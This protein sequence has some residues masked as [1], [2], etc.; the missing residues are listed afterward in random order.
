MS[1]GVRSDAAA[2]ARSSVADGAG[3]CRSAA[4][5]L[6]AARG[7]LDLTFGSGGKVTTD[8]GGNRN[9]LGLA[10]QADRK[11]VAAGT[12]FD[13]G[14]SDDFVLAR[15]TA[16]GALDATFDRDGKVTTD[17]G[18]GSDGAH[19]VAIQADGKIVAA[20]RGIPVQGRPLDFALAVQPRRHAGRHVRRRWQAADNVRAEQHRRRERR[21]HPVGRQDRRRGS[22]RSGPTRRV[23]RREVPPNGSLDPSF[24]GDG[25]VVAAIPSGAV[26]DL[27]VQPDGKLIAAG[28]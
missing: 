18:G 26:F 25:L 22:T 9:S 27:A 2:E 20:G 17:F 28:W 5:A 16:R 8:F 4:A 14:P 12:R 13:P 23:R 11:A 19:D 3:S 1:I 6:P 24:D 10:V 15:Y 21:P 7:D